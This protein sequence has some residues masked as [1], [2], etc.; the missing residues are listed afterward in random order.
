MLIKIRNKRSPKIKPCG[1]PE[2]TLAQFE[3]YPFKSTR[4]FLLTR[5]PLVTCQK[6]HKVV[7]HI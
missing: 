3:H 2:F 4:R 1:T 6:H 7:V 5:K